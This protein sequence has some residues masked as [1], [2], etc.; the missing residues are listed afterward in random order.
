MEDDLQEHVAKFLAQLGVIAVCYGVK[1]LICFFDEVLLEAV[2]GL[3]A[4]PWAPSRPT[5]AIHDSL[6]PTE[7]I[8]VVDVGGVARGESLGRLDAVV[9]GHGA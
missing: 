7:G 1:H 3:L 9:V 5:Q 6:K 2:V 4:I 8:G